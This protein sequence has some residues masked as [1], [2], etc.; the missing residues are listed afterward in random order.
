MLGACP[1]SIN[2]TPTI[3]LQDTVRLG[4]ELNLQIII[5]HLLYLFYLEFFTS[6]RPGKL[7]TSP[8]PRPSYTSSSLILPFGA[9][10]L[11]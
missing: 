5:S 2:L 9:N 4:G 6:N 1:C 11:L 10:A 7:Y 3:K 8:G